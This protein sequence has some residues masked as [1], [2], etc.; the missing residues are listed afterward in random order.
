MTDNP[1]ITVVIPTLNRPVRTVRAI[2]SLNDQ[3]YNGIINCV[4]ID[5]S[6]DTKTEDTIKDTNFTNSN[7]KINYLR[8]NHSVRPIDNWILGAKEINTEYG[9][10]LCDDDWL[11]KE[12]L[13]KCIKI[14]KNENTDSVISNI[15][16]IRDNKSNIQNYY[17]YSIS[18]VKKGNVVDS[19]LGLNNILPVTPS[20]SLT[21]SKVLLES[22]Y[23]S[24]KHIECT[25]NL[26]GFDFF[27]SYYPV[28]N[29]NGTYLIKEGLANSHAGNDSMTL[30]V[31]K[32]KIS[33]CYFFAL[34]NLI[35]STNYKVSNNQEKIIS[36]R[37]ATF[38][39]K[40]LFEKEYKSLE[41]DNSFISKL[42]ISKLLK[43][44]IQKYYLK[45]YYSLKK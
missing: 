33:Y 20:A 38:N 13:D 32:G 39:L 44:Q 6:N 30:N 28:F 31:K 25:E 2:S 40:K 19:F 8:N 17:K 14:L 3:T 37:L 5:S 36:H 34:I 24:L 15:N 27:M 22:F 41:L 9:K 26:F 21:K 35:E 12:Y 10:F 11:E 29:S 23:E 42:D 43:S 7:L 16:I 1:E 18:N 45:M 4:I